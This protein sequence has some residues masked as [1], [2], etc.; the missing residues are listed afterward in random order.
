VGV[1]TVPTQGYSRMLRVSP[2][3][4][5]NIE[6]CSHH[7]TSKSELIASCENGQCT[8]DHGDVAS[9]VSEDAREIASSIKIGITNVLLKY[10]VQLL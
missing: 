3:W 10:K 2:E 1:L 6:I 9:C 4:D 8:S 5:L 7:A